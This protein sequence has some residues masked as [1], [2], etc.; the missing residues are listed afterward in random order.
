MRGSRKERK[1]AD[2]GQPGSLFAHQTQITSRDE[3]AAS[4]C[5]SLLLFSASLLFCFSLCALVEKEVVT[6]IQLLLPAI[7]AV[8][9]NY[10]GGIRSLSAPFPAFPLGSLDLFILIPWAINP[11]TMVRSRLFDI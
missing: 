5:V 4:V 8:P 2:E 9:A 10:S 3:A 11:E 1:E 7:P 6:T